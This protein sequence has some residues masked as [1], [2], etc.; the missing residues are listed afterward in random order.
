M[1]R[2]ILAKEWGISL[3]IIVPRDEYDAILYHRYD[4]VSGLS[5][6]GQVTSAF[7]GSSTSEPGKAERSISGRTFVIPADAETGMDGHR[8]GLASAPPKSTDS[9]KP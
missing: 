7:G 8:A 3:G 6:V 2:S 9:C 4:L 5:A 1:F